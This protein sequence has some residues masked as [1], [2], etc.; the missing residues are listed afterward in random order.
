MIL[1]LL[2][3]QERPVPIEIPM[4]DGKSLA[5]DLRL[6]S[7]DYKGPTV[8]VQTP[9]N[10][11]L[12]KT[13]IE[14]EYAWV[15]VDWRGFYGSKSAGQILNR[16]RDGF[17][18]VEWVAKQPWSD[19][20]V[21]T[22]GPSA[23]GRIQ[24]LTAAERP[25]H[26]VCCVPLVASAPFYYAQ[27]YW[28]GVPRKEL[29]DGYDRL[30]FVTGIRQHPQYD[31]FW[32]IAESSPKAADMDVPML[33]VSGWY[34][35]YAQG[36]IDTF[37]LLRRKDR[38]LILGPWIHHDVVK[39]EQGERKYEAAAG[40][41]K[42]ETER[43]LDHHLRG[44]KNGW[45]K[46]P[47]IRAYQ[48]GEEKWI[49]CERWPGEAKQRSFPLRGEGAIVHDPGDPVPTVGGANLDPSLG[50]GP[51]DQAK[52]ASRKDVFVY[53]VALDADV[54][55][56]GRARVKLQATSDAK[57]FDLHVRL[58]SGTMLVVD[59]ARRTAGG[60]VEI[61]L[62]PFALTFAKG[63]EIRLIV[64]G[65]NY[66]RYDLS[67]EKATITVKGGELVLPVR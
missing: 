37:E 2:L 63:Q 6:P 59:S 52:I 62:P 3:L 35:I 58:C 20:K 1:L 15:I 40:V 17:D 26:L 28:G 42:R 65:S 38:W 51:K 13:P 60:E 50:L 12:W 33:L 49:E 39:A 43:F 56:A 23:L 54:A 45:E 46:S 31:A 53:A 8:L 32:K 5:A 64:S 48:M 55:V 4:R 66:P 22:W 21:A 18:C 11:K 19:G 10:R 61:E 25:P 14:G 7:K 36:V 67:P 44:S 30:G 16:G 57:S 9:Y 24:F 47:P 27:Y 34:D 41:V 29:L